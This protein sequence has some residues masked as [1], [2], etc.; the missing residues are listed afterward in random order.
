V[1]RKATLNAQESA[2]T[3]N[4]TGDQVSLPTSLNCEADPTVS[5][6]VAFGEI[7]EQVPGP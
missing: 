2:M 4:K 5:T 7:F 6:D 1:F 3:L